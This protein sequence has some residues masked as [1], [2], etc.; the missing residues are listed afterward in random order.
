MQRINLELS[1]FSRRSRSIAFGHVG[2][3]LTAGL[4]WGDTV[5][6]HDP[7]DA[8]WFLATVADLDFEL[9][10]T[11]YRLEIG[12]RITASEAATWLAPVADEHDRVS[13]QGLMALLGELR[14][15]DRALQAVLTDTAGS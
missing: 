13:A 9:E 3:G 12:A 1:P 11:R 8:S 5:V 4:T 15:R 14:Q 2:S 10:D 7:I 6:V